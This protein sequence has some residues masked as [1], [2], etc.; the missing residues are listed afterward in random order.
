MTIY[1]VD[2]GSVHP[3]YEITHGVLGMGGSYT[4]DFYFPGVPVLPG[5]S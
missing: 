2:C 3:N 4:L 5:M 1:M